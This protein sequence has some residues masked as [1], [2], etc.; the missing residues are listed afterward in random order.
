L[1]NFTDQRLTHEQQND[2]DLSQT[3]YSQAELSRSDARGGNSFKSSK[4]KK[5]TP[6]NATPVTV[7]ANKPM[8]HIP[9]RLIDK[10]EH[11]EMHEKTATSG[12]NSEHAAASNSYYRSG[13]P[14]P[15]SPPNVSLNHS[16]QQT[17]IFKAVSFF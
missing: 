9:T 11:E 1:P 10:A 17:E 15:H 4:K 6:K 2:D 12:R 3:G 14:R 8:P 13:M 7:L 5:K 16:L